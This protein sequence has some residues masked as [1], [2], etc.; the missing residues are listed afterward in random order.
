MGVHGWALGALITTAALRLGLYGADAPDFLARA[1]SRAEA[2]ARGDAARG[3]EWPPGVPDFLVPRVHFAPRAVSERG[4]WHD[5]AGAL[6]HKGVHHVYQGEGWNHALSRDLVRWS[7]GPKG[8]DRLRE[9]YAGMDSYDNP[10]S[11]Y[12][13]VDDD[14]AVC[15]GFRQCTSRRGVAGGLS[16]DVPLELRCALDDDLT[17]WSREPEYLF[18]VSWYRSIPYDPARPWREADGNWYQLLAMDGCNATTR[19][20][21]CEMGGQLQLWTSPA[22]RG[23]RAAWRHLGPVFTSNATALRGAHLTKEFVTI[24]FLGGLAGDPEPAGLG[25]RLFLNN[26]GGNGGGVGC[27][28]GSTSYFVVEQAAPGAPMREVGP[29][30]MVDWGAFRLRSGPRPP[31]A[32]PAGLELLDGTG[33]RGFSMARTLGSEGADQVT[34]PGRRVLIGWTG[35][36]DTLKPGLGSA[37]SL[38]RELSLGPDRRLRQ[39]FVPELQRLRRG[40]PVVATAEAAWSPRPVGM[41]CEVVA[42]LPKACAAAH[43]GCGVA[44]L[45]NAKTATRITLATELGLVLVDATS[46]NNTA[47]RGGPLPPPDAAGGW[48]IHA[49]A[50]RSIV[51]VIVNNVTAL[52][53]YAAP[54]SAAASGVRLLGAPADLSGARLEAWQLDDPGH[55]Y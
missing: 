48:T 6:T 34:V 19:R 28:A 15:A 8:P 43:A 4:S 40:P 12:L 54:A 11:G 36:A 47:V 22:L 9:T 33:S 1:A 46:Q 3:L 13:A 38:P 42:T 45:A 14:G 25:T 10:C 35:P 16:W 50:D 41:Q 31:T 2:S 20:L 23:P 17:A 18:N 39:A 37:Q 29:Q 24:D 21:P 5:I 53:V 49:Y 51:E 26:V 55:A 44:V 30:G 7:A 32:Q 52:V 27:C